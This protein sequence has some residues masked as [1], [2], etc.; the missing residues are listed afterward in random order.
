MKLMKLLKATS[1]TLSLSSMVIF[2]KAHAYERSS[3]QLK[4]TLKASEETV[5]E[6]ARKLLEESFSFS[7]KVVEQRFLSALHR[8]FFGQEQ[9][10]EFRPGQRPTEFSWEVQTENTTIP[11]RIDLLQIPDD[12]RNKI[13][14]SIGTLSL[15][16]AQS[17]LSDFG[18]RNVPDFSETSPRFRST[19]GQRSPRFGPYVES[20]QGFRS[21]IVYPEDVLDGL[22]Y[23]VNLDCFYWQSNS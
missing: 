20:Y 21:Q 16:N 8:D 10:F 11:L 9:E 2:V 5:L 17:L 1:L 7:G 13:Q 19:W 4:C 23:Y 22:T 14:L 15:E 3:F 12:Y 6:P 18:V